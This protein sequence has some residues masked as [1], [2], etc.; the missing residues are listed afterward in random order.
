MA[1]FHSLTI[2]FADVLWFGCPTMRFVCCPWF[3]VLYCGPLESYNHRDDKYIA[4][5]TFLTATARRDVDELNVWA[6]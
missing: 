3:V 4:F 1:A 2:N 6:L 5:F